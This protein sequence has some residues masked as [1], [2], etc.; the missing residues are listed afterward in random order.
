MQRMGTPGTDSARA[1]VP[2]RENGPDDPGTPGAPPS[3]SLASAWV[4][5]TI[6][7]CVTLA[8]ALTSLSDRSLWL[9]EA[10]T[11]AV[12]TAPTGR[13]MDDLAFNG[14]NM[15]LYLV[16]MRGWVV[17]GDSDWWIRL[18]SALF[19]SACVPCFFAMARRFVNTGA[20]V[21][22]AGLLGISP[23]LLLHSQ[24]PVRIHSLFCS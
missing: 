24:E 3:G 7:S 22:G 15:A 13:F 21:A 20:A 2:P 12:A 8:L 1:Q 16:F 19:A 23:P 14:G 9:D 5:V 11:T 10:F 18:P 17:A 6:F 4:L